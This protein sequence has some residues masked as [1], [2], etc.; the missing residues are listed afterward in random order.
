MQVIRAY[1]WRRKKEEKFPKSRTSSNQLNEMRKK[2]ARCPNIADFRRIDQNDEPRYS[3]AHEGR[4]RRKKAEMVQLRRQAQQ[5]EESVARTRPRRDIQ[6]VLRYEHS[7]LLAYALNVE[8]SPCEGEPQGY[9]EAMASIDSA[10]MHVTMREEM[11]SLHN[12]NTWEL[13]DMKPTMKVIRCRWLYK[14][15]P[16]R[17]ID[18]T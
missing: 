8:L 16:W 2:T 13:V 6:P 5:E 1:L 17:R 3:E 18:D 15:D 9:E 10:K 12:N 4:T 14:I 11:N 7:N